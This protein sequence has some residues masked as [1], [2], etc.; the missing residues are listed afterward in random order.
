MQ[1]QLFVRNALQSNEIGSEQAS[2][3]TMACSGS[4]P[5]RLGVNRRGVRS[6]LL[7]SGQLAWGVT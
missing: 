4:D 7:R 5:A 1:L 6:D 2:L 3:W